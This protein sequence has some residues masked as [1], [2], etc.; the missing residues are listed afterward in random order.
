MSWLFNICLSRILWKIKIAVLFGSISMN[1]GSSVTKGWVCFCDYF[2]YSQAFSSAESS[3]VCWEC[4]PYIK[5]F[6]A[7][8]KYLP[9]RMFGLYSGSSEIDLMQW[10]PRLRTQLQRTPELL[11]GPITLRALLALLCRA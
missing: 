8:I 5:D 2:G 1:W 3:Q 11:I 6:I 4:I 7:K 9:F 10:S